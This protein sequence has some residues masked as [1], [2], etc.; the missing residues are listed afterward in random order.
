M[1]RYGTR[2][3]CLVLGLVAALAIAATG[4]IVVGGT[5]RGST[6]QDAVVGRIVVAH[7]D[8]ATARSSRIDTLLETAKG[9]VPL[10]LA[11]GLPAAPGSRISVRHPRYVD[12]AI[13]AG[14]L[15]KLG[16]PGPTYGDTKIGPVNFTPGPRKV[17]VLL[18]QI[19]GQAAPGNADAVR[20]AIFTAPNSANAFVNEETFGQLSLT[21]KLRSD[22]DVYGPYT[23]GSASGTCDSVNWGTS[24]EAAFKAATGMD[25]ETWDNV[26]F[27][28]QATA[29]N[30]SGEGEIGQLV[31]GKARH[32]WVN[33]TFTNGVPTTSVVAHELGHNFGV[34]HAGGFNCSVNGVRVSFTEA[35]A[36]DPAQNQY[37]DPFDVMGNG[38]RQENAYHK[39]ESGWLPPSSAQ[40][41]VRDGTYLIAPEDSAS[42]AVQLLEVPREVAL[43]VPSY[44][45]DFRQPFGSYFDN[46]SATDPVVQGVSIRYANSSAMPHPSKSW[47]IDTTPATSTFADAALGLGQ[48]FSDP[49][50]GVSITTLAVSPLG[51]LVRISIA[52]GADTTPPG[53]PSG[54]TVARGGDGLDFA[55]TPADDDSGTA[56]HYR[57]RRNGVLLADVWANTAVDPSPLAGRTSSYDVSAVDPSGNEGH[58]ARID[59]AI[60]DVSAPAA[61]TDLAATVKGSAVRVSWSPATDDV[62]VG[63]YEVDRDGQPIAYGLQ[64][65]QIGDPGV[66]PGTHAYTVRAI[67]TSGNAGPFSPPL[68]VVVSGSAVVQ[69]GTSARLKTVK[70]VKVRRVGKHRVLLSWKAQRGARRYQVLRA[71]KKPLLLAT[72]KK[73][74]YTDG[75]APTGKLTAAR[76]VVRAVLSS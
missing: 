2:A 64:A 24:G 57:L 59:V 32:A 70:T 62:A 8:G 4:L 12:G 76:Y 54:L 40:T 28:F 69:A 53:S 39:W 58:A 43:A 16:P 22:G 33:P 55:W 20:G 11:S 10:H 14:D 72:V 25:A 75:K 52:N 42:S 9:L 21:G 68:N 35:C 17:L 61:P 3:G 73:V 51:A 45:L 19:P 18:L 44:W 27:V 30:F 48:T 5:S 26:I 34:D 50:R 36:T 29:C 13:V 47:L 7:Q 71:G 65:T 49:G 63:S 74:Q 67:D 38:A 15:A 31:A 60:S 1:L 41:V 6:P 37:A 46:F 23:V 56:Q 66:S